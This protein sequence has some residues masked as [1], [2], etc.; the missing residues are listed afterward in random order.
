MAN[1]DKLFADLESMASSANISCKEFT[2]LLENFGFEI[3]HCKSG[4]HKIAKH[5]AI[6]LDEYPNYNCGHNAGDAIRRPYIKKLLTFVKLHKE[7][8]KEHMK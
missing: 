4:G 3:T 2:S 8:I 5:P 7:T 1:F 6:P